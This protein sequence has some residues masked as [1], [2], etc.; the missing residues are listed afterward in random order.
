MVIHDIHVIVKVLDE[1]EQSAQETSRCSQD[2]KETKEVQRPGRVVEQK[3]N[4]DQIQQYAQ[5]AR[6]VVNKPW[7]LRRVVLK[8]AVH[9]DDNFAVRV[10]KAGLERRCLAKVSSQTNQGHAFIAVRNFSEDLV[11]AIATSIVDEYHLVRV[12][13]TIHD[14]DDTLVERLDIV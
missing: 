2:A 14:F 10:I 3:L 5:R 12:A 6:D 11:G 4:T 13:E 8:I 7:Y 9:R 1:Q